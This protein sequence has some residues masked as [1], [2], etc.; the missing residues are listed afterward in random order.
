[1]SGNSVGYRGNPALWN[2]AGQARQRR[3]AALAAAAERLRE[4]ERESSPI[5]VPAPRRKRTTT[6]ELAPTIEATPEV[7]SAIETQES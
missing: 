7:A 6:T 4:L 5:V 1:M 3:E 2:L